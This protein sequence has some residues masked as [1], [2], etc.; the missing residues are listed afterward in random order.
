MTCSKLSRTSST[1][2]SASHSTRMVARPTAPPVSTRPSVVRIGDATRRRI[3]DRLERD[4]PDPVGELVGDVGGELER[5]PGLAGPAGP[6]QRQQPGRRQQLAGLAS[7]PRPG[8]RSSS[9]GS[10]GCSAGGRASGSAGSR[11]GGPR[12]TSWQIRSGRR[13]LSRC[14]PRPAQRDAGRQLVRDERSTSPPRA[15]PGRRGRPPRPGPPGG[16]RR[17]RT[18]RRRRAGRRRCGCP[19]G[20]GRR[21]VRPRLGGER[22]LGVDGGG[23]ARRHVR[24]KTTKKPSPSVFPRR[25]PW[26]RDG[27][28]DELAMAGEERRPALAGSAWASCVEPSMSVNRKV[29]GPDRAWRSSAAMARLDVSAAAA[30][31]RAAAGPASPRRIASAIVG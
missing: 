8:R 26:R 5:Q 1:S 31:S 25:P 22:P 30:R 18:R 13:S 24:A 3:A 4:E 14:S 7:A 29:D 2:R 9:A 17:R 11:P 16:R 28:P 15:G 19:S 23:D 20:P 12:S 27:R 21:A 6:G 10:A